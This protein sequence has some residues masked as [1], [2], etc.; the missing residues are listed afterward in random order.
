MSR[1]LGV[2]Q[3]PRGNDPDVDDEEVLVEVDCFLMALR[4]IGDGPGLGIALH[5]GNMLLDS[6]QEVAGLHSPIHRGVSDHCEQ[7]EMARY[8]Y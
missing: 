5:S 1:T 8:R 4:I 6:R 2:V 3:K 7:L